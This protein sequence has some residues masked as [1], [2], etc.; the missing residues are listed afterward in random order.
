MGISMRL[1]STGLRLL[2]RALGAAWIIAVVAGL[3]WLARYDNAPGAAAAAEDHGPAAS[4]L[5]LDAARPTLVMLA[6]PRCDCTRATIAELAEIIA[7]A[8]SRPKT[9]V[10]FI[11]PAA[12]DGGWEQTDL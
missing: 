12:V 8:H 7:R 4:R 5:T 1:R 10:V 2:W 9:Y 11:K 6:H 3:S